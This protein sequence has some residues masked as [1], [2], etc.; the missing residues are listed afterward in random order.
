[1]IDRVVDMSR[2][3][4]LVTLIKKT[5]PQR[6][7]M[8]RATRAPVVGSLIERM[9]FKGDD[10]MFLPQDRVV[11]V[12]EAIESAGQAVLPSQL[13]E[14]FIESTDY[15]WVMDNCICREAAGCRDYPHDLGCLF[16]GEAALGINPR[17]GRRVDRSEALEHA[18]RCR[19]AGLVH[20]VGLNKLDTVWLGVGPGNKLLTICNCCP[21]CC[22][23]R[24]IPQLS[25]LI[26]DKVTRMPGVTVTV[27]ERCEGCGTCAAGTCFVDAIRI[28]DGKALIAEACRGCGRCVEVC[29]NEAIEISVEGGYVSDAMERLSPHFDLT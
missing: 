20:L 5:F 8:A 12:D 24:M 9:L 6:F 14:R 29:P 4:W 17:L 1:M 2:P 23:W 19:E 15:H 13:V 11:R 7:M 10:I 21:C 16:L 27:T 25:P 3:V 28:D 22:L 26:A 18:R